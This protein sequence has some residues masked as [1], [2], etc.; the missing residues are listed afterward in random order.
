MGKKS[1]VVLY[2][3]I[4]LMAIFMPLL[5]GITA[6]AGG[7]RDELGSIII[8]VLDYTEDTSEY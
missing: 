8:E 5:T 6:N 1:I 3:A 4:L 7:P 2:L